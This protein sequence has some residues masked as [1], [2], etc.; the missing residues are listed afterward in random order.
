M[1]LTRKCSKKLQTTS[2]AFQRRNR[3]TDALRKVTDISG[4]KPGRWCDNSRTG[5]RHRETK[6]SVGR[7]QNSSKEP[8]KKLNSHRPRQEDV[9]RIGGGLHLGVEAKNKKGKDQE[10][11]SR[12]SSVHL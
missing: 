7:P 2:Y 9:E 10:S 5:G 4:N 11:R 3:V 1:T 6:R 8:L 12:I